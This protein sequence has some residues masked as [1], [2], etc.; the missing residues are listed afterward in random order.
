MDLELHITADHQKFIIVDET[1]KAD[2]VKKLPERV[3]KEP[4]SCHCNDENCPHKSNIS[5]IGIYFFGED[6]KNCYTINWDIFDYNDPTF[7][8]IQF[9]SFEEFANQISYTKKITQNPDNIDSLYLRHRIPVEFTYDKYYNGAVCRAF[10]Q[11][12]LWSLI[13]GVEFE[14]F[15]AKEIKLY[16]SE[17][18]YNFVMQD[19]LT[20][21]VPIHVNSCQYSNFVLVI[22]GAIKAKAILHCGSFHKE[23][24]SK[25][26][27]RLEIKTPYKVNGKEM[28]SI[29]NCG[30]VIIS[31]TK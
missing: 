22:P 5:M 13:E 19:T 20:W 16:I 30:T 31:D 15:T 11:R 1:R 27:S 25:L 17:Y 3:F 6:I 18:P 14:S 9:D 29:H 21:S 10:N 26:P 4:S 8:I 12:G 7:P 2:L 23:V 28:F 24:Q